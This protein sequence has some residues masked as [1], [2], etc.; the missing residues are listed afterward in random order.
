ML[1]ETCISWLPGAGWSS[2]G[3]GSCCRVLETWDR[4]GFFP[5]GFRKE[6]DESASLCNFNATRH[7]TNI[8]EAYLSLFLLTCVSLGMKLKSRKLPV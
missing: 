6:A 1:T 2:V 7:A 3:T 5:T 8:C 4:K